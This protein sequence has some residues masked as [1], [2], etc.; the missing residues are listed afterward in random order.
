MTLFVWKN[1]TFRGGGNEMNSIEEFYLKTKFL[2]IFSLFFVAFLMIRYVSSNIDYADK[3][4]RTVMCNFAPSHPMPKQ[5]ENSK[6]RSM[7]QMMCII[8]SRR[9]L[10]DQDLD[11]NRLIP[12]N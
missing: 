1:K 7:A 10:F 4:K 9:S 12:D 6:E 8:P 3:S 5:K 11:E 2:L